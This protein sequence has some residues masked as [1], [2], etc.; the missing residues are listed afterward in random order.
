[1]MYLMIINRL[2]TIL[3]WLGFLAG[4]SILLYQ[5]VIS[6]QSVQD[7]HLSI[8]I[9][10]LGIAL[11]IGIVSFGVQMWA[12]QIIMAA[13]GVRLSYVQVLDGYLPSFL[14]RYLPGTIWGYLSRGEWLY[15]KFGVSYQLSGFGSFLEIL[16]SL[17]SN[18]IVIGL[19]FS[20]S[21]VEA[22]IIVAS[23]IILSLALFG[24]LSI[25]RKLAFK[26]PWFKKLWPSSYPT[27]NFG[28]WITSILLFMCTWL[29]YGIGLAFVLRGVAAI[30]VGSQVA[31]WI[32]LG[33]V[34]SIAWLFGFL[35]L[36]SPAGL[37]FR[38]LAMAV[39]VSS[40]FFLTFEMGGTIGVIARI[41]VMLS[42][43][44]WVAGVLLIQGMNKN[45]VRR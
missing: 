34:Y 41:T 17:I 33:G 21:V 7:K 31:D 9:P 38:E 37:G 20:T 18:V 26:W 39:L 29:L 12:W 5:I 45:W 27:L 23:G 24:L 4:G 35:V 28:L 15:Q 11:A 10:A 13:L 16:V 36:I 3:R 42:E 32:H 6:I 44:I 43:L 22:V 19:G 25:S 14:P 40:Q 8:N 30:D 1:M 2:R